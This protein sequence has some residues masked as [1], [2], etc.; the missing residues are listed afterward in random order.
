MRRTRICSVHCLCRVLHGVESIRWSRF[1]TGL[2]YRA[3]T[4]DFIAVVGL[5]M[6]PHRRSRNQSMNVLW[7]DKVVLVATTA[8]GR[9]RTNIELTTFKFYGCGSSPVPILQY[10]NLTVEGDCLFRIIR[11]CSQI[12]MNDKHELMLA[13]CDIQT[14]TNSSGCR[15]RFPH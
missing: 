4:G 14:S 3:S 1:S 2:N 7:R 12:N 8:S 11:Y 9:R 6:I 5:P 10:R 15:F 13:W